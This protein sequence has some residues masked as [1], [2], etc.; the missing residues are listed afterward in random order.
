[1]KY[2]PIDP[3]LFVENRKRLAAQMKPNSVAFVH[4]NDIMPTNADGEMPFRQNNDLLYLTG[5]DQEE[6]VLLLFPDAP[7]EK[8][9]EMLFLRETSEKIAIWEGAKLTKEQAREA[10]GIQHVHWLDEFE[11]NFRQA[12]VLAD[13]VY[14]NH[15]EYLR[16][17]DVVQT[18]ERRFID[19]C[20]RRWPLHDYQRLAPIMHS[21][22]CIKSDIE[23]DLIKHACAITEA[24]FR[25]VCEFVKPG[26]GEWEVEA[27][28]AHEFLR[29]KS[30]GFAYNPIIASGRNACVL[31][32]VTND[33]ECKDGDLL[34]MDVAAEYAN[35]NADMT[36]TIPVNGRFTERQRAVYDAVLRVFRGACEILRPGIINKDYQEQVGLMTEKELIDLGLLDA[37]EVKNQPEEE[38]KE[39]PL[40]KK[41]FMHGT[42]HHL[43]L[44][45]HDVGHPYQPVEEGMV[46]TV[47][48]GIYIP[49]ENF[50]VRLENDILIGKDENIDLMESIPIEAEAIEEMMNS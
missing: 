4:S 8:H 35:Y 6:S 19:E 14:L 49:D 5:V 28:Y 38:K 29:S 36:R 25:R 17:S 16:A 26:V 15:N 42:S 33:A 34:L 50:G 44:D 43:G 13:H 45:V 27:E 23:V 24:G 18:R 30:K 41:Y 48:P 9:R 20:Q 40:Y 21:L 37:E 31:H 11:L 39:K 2:D 12:M 32:Y 10:T 22:R 1:M 47:E 46:F 3:Q 7:E